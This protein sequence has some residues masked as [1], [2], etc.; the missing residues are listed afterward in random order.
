M[1]DFYHKDGSAGYIRFIR[2]ALG[3]DRSSSA[4]TKK[5]T[6]FT[7]SLTRR[8]GADLDAIVEIR[9][10]SLNEAFLPAFRRVHELLRLRFWDGSFHGAIARDDLVDSLQ[11]GSLQY[12]CLT[13]V[14]FKKL[15]TE[16]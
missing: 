8:Q 12:D 4:S 16:E 5:Q 10:R 6:N 14:E 1:I 7:K 9:S 3:N 11:L 15:S 2:V 13:V